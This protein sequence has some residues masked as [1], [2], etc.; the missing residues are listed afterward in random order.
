M[1][2]HAIGAAVRL[3]T[4]IRSGSTLITPA[5]ISLT[6]L[7]PDGTTTAPLTP[8]ADGV[9]LYH[10]DY[11]PPLAGRYVA[12]WV[13]AGPAGAD[14]E[15][16]DVAAL[17]GEAGIVSLTDAK[18]Q[19]N[20]PADVTT[21]DEELAGF[22]RAVTEP[23]E[24]IVGSI[25]RRT[26][27]ERHSGGYALALNRPPVLSLIQVAAIRPG[28]TAPALA[29]LDLDG[30]TGIVTRLDGGYLPGPLRVTYLP[31]RAEVPAH[32]RQAALLIIQH[33]WETQRGQMGGVR[34]GG[35]DEVYDPRFGFS[36]PRRAQELLGDQPP[37][38]A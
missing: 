14:E 1:A 33:M 27:T 21:D 23:I 31:G 26:V 9:G 11:T 3:T 15:G 4:E 36:I 20:I 10:Y 22:I 13:T 7:L 24:R 6:I 35:S 28:G 5:G 12:R 29:D 34:R 38:I 18:D 37:A 32:V 30:P 2:P 16:F 19:T 25:V 17:W 8:T